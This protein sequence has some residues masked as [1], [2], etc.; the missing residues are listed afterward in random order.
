ML[1]PGGAVRSR[2]PLRYHVKFTLL[3]L[4]G[5]HHLGS[6]VVTVQCNAL[7]VNLN[8]NMMTCNAGARNVFSPSEGMQQSEDDSRRLHRNGNGKTCA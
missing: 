2:D 7:N 4:E 6:D 1:F 5:V 3:E 8:V